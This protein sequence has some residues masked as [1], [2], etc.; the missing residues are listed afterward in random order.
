MRLR[1]WIWPA[2]ASLVAIA[3]VVLGLLLV[4]RLGERAIARLQTANAAAARDHFVAFAHPAFGV[5]QN[6]QSNAHQVAAALG[7]HVHVVFFT[8]RIQLLI[9]RA[10]FDGPIRRRLAVLRMKIEAALGQ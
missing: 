2:A 4:D 3:A 6:A 9:G 8:V 1:P 10:E 5:L 7:L